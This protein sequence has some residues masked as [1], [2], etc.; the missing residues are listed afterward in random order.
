[1]KDTAMRIKTSENDPFLIGELPLGQGLIG[2]SICP[3]SHDYE[4][5]SGPRERSLEADLGAVR[6]GGYG[7]VV[8]LLEIWELDFLRVA[9]MGESVAA[10][11][12]SWWHLPVKDCCPLEYRGDGFAEASLDRWSWPCALLLCFLHAG[13]KVFIH[14]R[15]GLGRTGTLAALLLIKEGIGAGDAIT[16]VRE[17]RP[18]AVPYKC[19]NDW[20]WQQSA[21][22]SRRADLPPEDK[23]VTVLLREPHKF[24]L[25]TWLQACCRAF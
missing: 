24:V 12:M 5:W 10:R 8:T 16:M 14:C 7:I 3:G 17:A 20:L 6:A 15:G 23:A 25:E 9:G 4:A 21:L 13:G 22:F 1:M 2:M 18:G 19:Q 11:G